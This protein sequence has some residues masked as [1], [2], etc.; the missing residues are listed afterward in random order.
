MKMMVHFL[1][2]RLFS[3]PL[4]LKLI[5]PHKKR[6]GKIVVYFRFLSAQKLTAPMMLATA[7][8]AIM[9]TSVVI[10]GVSGVGSG[11]EG[12]GSGVGSGVGWCWLRCRFR[13]RLWRRFRRR[14]RRRLWRGRRFRCRLR[15][16]WS[17][18]C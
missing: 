3:P 4:C 11:V 2:L 14:F 16:Y 17:T 15:F 13:R 12:D 7:T 10:K 1:C 8:A 18:W 5:T 9:A 6:G